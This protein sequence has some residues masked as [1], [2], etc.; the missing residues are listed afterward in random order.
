MDDIT[1]K[2]I[3]NLFRLKSENKAIKDRMIGGIKTFLSMKKKITTK[4]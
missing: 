2:G 3:R 4:Q 1:I